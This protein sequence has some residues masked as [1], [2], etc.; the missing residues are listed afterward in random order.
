VT[1]IEPSQLPP[2]EEVRDA[3]Q[4]EWFAARRATIL[5]EQYQKL[6]ANYHVRVE[7]LNDTPAGQ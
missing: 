3:V 4:R 6:Q 5:D 1:A 7:G 2:F